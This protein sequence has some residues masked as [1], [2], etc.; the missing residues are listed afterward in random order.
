MPTVDIDRDAAREAAQ[1][2][3]DKPIYPRTSLTDRLSELVNDLI[4]RIAAGG[5]GVPGGWLTISV[6]GLLLT[7]AVVVAVRVARSTMRTDRGNHSLYGGH[8]LCAAEH[9]VTAEQHA[10]AGQWALAIRH[11]LR[12]VARQLEESG[13]LAAVPGRTATELAN[14]AGLALPH[15]SGALRAAAT[16]FN[17]VTYG[18][19]P[20]SEAA[21]RSVAALDD[22]IREAAT[23]AGHTSAAPPAGTDWAE[24]R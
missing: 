22:H 11:R 16:A 10:A 4:Y 15:L 21:Y 18:D 20:G 7:V 13:V 2:E 12:A 17:D 3:L 9:R 24:V 6:L 5:A 23:T 1:Q 14:D 8:E 19:R